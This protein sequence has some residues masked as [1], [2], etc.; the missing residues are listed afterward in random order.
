[1]V[2]EALLAYAHLLAILTMVVFLET[3]QR[4]NRFARCAAS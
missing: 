4:R 1:M 3:C 2:Q